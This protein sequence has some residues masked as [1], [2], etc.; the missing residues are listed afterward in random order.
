MS[1]CKENRGRY[2][3][4]APLA[5]LACAWMPS[6]SMAQPTAQ[7]YPVRPIRLVVPSPPGGGTDILG[8]ML[9]QKLTIS[10]RNQIIIDN[11][12]G[13]SGI[14]G[15][16]IVAR[17]DPD[18][19]TLLL[20]FTTHVTN[21]TLYPKMP[22]D[23]LRDFASV[24]MVGSIPAVL[25]LHPSIPSQNVK[26]FIAYAKERPGKLAYGS[27]GNGSALHLSAVLF[28]IMTGTSMIHVPYKGSAPALADVLGGQLNLMFSNIVSALPHARTGKLRALAVTSAKR[29]T[30][31]PELP[32]LAE[33]GLPGYEAAAWYALF[34]PARTPAPIISKLNSEVNTLMKM[35][36]VTERLLS[37]GA[38]SVAMSPRELSAYVETE[39]VKWGKL[40][41]ASGAK[42]D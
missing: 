34:A 25:V 11:R 30:S 41:K 5:G 8:R 36:D 2:K 3:W 38:E 42:V 18:G 29:L 9:A 32:T 15:S 39:I 13:A 1:N 26:E 33:S 28:N 4:L 7:A 27:A 17:A 12:G 40:I 6:A 35:P 37:L 14:I 31:A 23:T 24:A 20:C 16:E 22:Y 10:L 19:H 21:P